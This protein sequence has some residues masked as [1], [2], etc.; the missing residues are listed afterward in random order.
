MNNTLTKR[1]AALEATHRAA[2]AAGVE[3]LADV[4]DNTPGLLQRLEAGDVGAF[5]ELWRAAQTRL[6]LGW[7]ER[8]DV[9]A[10]ILAVR[11]D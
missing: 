9:A 4:I 7:A 3:Q 2:W 8:M 6:G 1:I 5:D 11:H 10:Q